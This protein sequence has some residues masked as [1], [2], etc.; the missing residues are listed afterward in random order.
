MSADSRMMRERDADL[1]F[2]LL[3]GRAAALYE[4]EKTTYEEYQ[5]TCARLTAWRMEYQAARAALYLRGY[6]PTERKGI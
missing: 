5:A 1:A 3:W 4:L 6:L 2:Q